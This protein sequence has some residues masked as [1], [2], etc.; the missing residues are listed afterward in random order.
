MERRNEML[1]IIDLSINYDANSILQNINFTVSK[2][3]ILGIIGENGCGKSTLL[4]SIFS[5]LKPLSGRIIYNNCDITK[6]KPYEKHKIGI[7][8]CLQGGLTFPTFTVLE[9]LKLATNNES[10]Y[11]VAFDYFPELENI[12]SKR[13]GNLSGGQKQMLS[14]SMLLI[15]NAD[16][17]LLDEPTAGLSVQNTNRT[18]EFLQRIKEKNE[19]TILIVEHNYN[20]LFSLID[21]AIIIKNKTSTCKFLNSDFIKDDFIINNLYS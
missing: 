18:L 20:F 19:K 13:A 6:F 9:H 5:L 11:K 16:L 8:Y 1:N 7:A 21:H 15:Q 10:K 12:L 4:K 2:G 3:E 17:W 14:L